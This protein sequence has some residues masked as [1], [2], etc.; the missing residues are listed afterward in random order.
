MAQR[1]YQKHSVPVGPGHPVPGMILT[2]RGHTLTPQ[3]S[4]TLHTRPHRSHHPDLTPQHNNKEGVC[5]QGGLSPLLP[6][7]HLH[8]GFSPSP[9]VDFA[10]FQPYCH[11]K[12]GSL[13][14]LK[15]QMPVVSLHFLYSFPILPSIYPNPKPLSYCNSF[16][17]IAFMSWS[18]IM[19]S[20][21]IPPQ[22]QSN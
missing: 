18:P 15:V 20:F 10:C 5:S 1:L 22:G 9:H 6:P 16:H 13:D 7:P 11:F 14:V 12:R 21:F 4:P 17:I 19:N 8:G 3:C 2:G